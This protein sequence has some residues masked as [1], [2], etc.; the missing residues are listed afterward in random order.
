MYSQPKEFIPA[1]FAKRRQYSRMN[2]Y[3][4]M[5]REKVGSIKPQGNYTTNTQGKGRKEGTREEKKG[6]RMGKME[7]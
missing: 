6:I 4:T 1:L 5:G 2:A 3:S 7:D